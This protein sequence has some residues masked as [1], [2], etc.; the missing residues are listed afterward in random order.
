MRVVLSSYGWL[1][2]RVGDYSVPDTSLIFSVFSGAQ[3]ATDRNAIGLIGKS[4]MIPLRGSRFKEG[5]G[6]AWGATFNP[7]NSVVMAETRSDFESLLQGIDRR[8]AMLAPE[9]AAQEHSFVNTAHG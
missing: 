5:W 4:A 7:V 2:R 1:A 8:D 6:T 9:L 3:P